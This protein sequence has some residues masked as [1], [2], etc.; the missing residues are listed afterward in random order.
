[1][2][3]NVARKVQGLKEFLIWPSVIFVLFMAKL[4]ISLSYQWTFDFYRKLRLLAK[5]FI[6]G[7]I[8]I[9]AEQ[10]FVFLTTISLFVSQIFE[11]RRLNSSTCNWFKPWQGTSQNH[12]TC[13]VCQDN[14]E[15]IRSRNADNCMMTSY[16]GHLV[17]ER[18]LKQLLISKCENS[19][20]EN[21]YGTCPTC[22]N[23]IDALHSHP[24]Y[25]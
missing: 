7:Q 22:R 15:E 16:C 24:V 10:K 13:P 8:L 18:C 9:L 19:N 11:P 12:I 17:C 23:E 14:Y 4:L 3:R 25:L 20:C 1:M 5:S 21:I 6:Y 2:W